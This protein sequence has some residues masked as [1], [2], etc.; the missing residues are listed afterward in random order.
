MIKM[1]D[2]ELF[3]LGFLEELQ[4]LCSVEKTLRKVVDAV[5]DTSHSVSCYLLRVTS[6]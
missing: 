4:Q 6:V 5:S 2:S 3:S 1:L